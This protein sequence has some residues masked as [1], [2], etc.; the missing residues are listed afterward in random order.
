M[1]IQNSIADR[2]KMKIHHKY[3]M[4]A[5]F[6]LLPF[7]NNAQ[8]NPYWQEPS[9]E[10]VD[11]LKKMLTVSTNDTLKMYVDREIALYYQESNRPAALQYYEEM[12]TLARK[13]KQPVWEAE[14]LSRNGYVSCSIQNYSG[15]LKF[16]LVARSLASQD[17]IEKGMWR[18]ALLS[19]KND[20]YHARITVLAGIYQHLAIVNYFTGE[21]AKSLQLHQI[22]HQLNNQLQDDAMMSLSWMNS[23][24]AYR[25]QGNLDSAESAFNRSIIYSDRSGHKKY[26]GLTYWNLGKVYE[27]RNK[28]KEAKEFYRRSIKSNIESESPDFEGMAYQSLADISQSDGNADSLFYFSRKA[29][30]IYHHI[31]DTLGLIAANSSLSSAFDRVHQ[32]DSAYQYLKKAIA[33]KNGL[34]KE[35]RIKSFQVAGVSEQLKLEEQKAEQLRTISRIRTYSFIAGIILLIFIAAMLYRNSRRQRRDKIKIEQAYAE[36]KS[37][38]QQL[39]QSEKMASLGEL[40]AGI[41]HEIQNPLNFVNNFSEV[42]NELIDEMNEELN[43]GDIEEAKIISSDIKQNLEKIN[44]HGKRADAIVKGML[45]HSQSSSGK[46]ES[47]NIN[48]LAD[49]YLR[50]AYHGIRAK[51]NSFNA[52]LKTDFDETIGHINMIPQDIGRVLLNLLNNAFYA[53]DQKKKSGIE[54]YEPTVSISTKKLADKVEIKVTDNGNGIPQK[55]V[56]KIF[57]PFFTTKPTGQGTGLGLSLSYDIIKA[58]RGEIKMNNKE[59]DGTIFT[60]LLPALP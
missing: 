56:D 26:K 58:H 39:I 59:N 60:I 9:R 30:N 57:Q 36:L 50:L 23:G 6:L 40:T 47:T 11:S 48:K 18:P 14:A 45:Q 19:F 12:L 51:D 55:I 44:H 46:K 8:N 5:C 28:P 17:G 42:S 32:M 10:Q 20:A 38:Q 21:Y 34:N 43:K 1:Y 13:T 3:L 15:G 31:N 2:I 52:T 7:Y 53:V 49:E 4:I 29:L 22:V 27:Q 37:T 54:G 35:E 16:L 33:L 24:E 41:A 25:G